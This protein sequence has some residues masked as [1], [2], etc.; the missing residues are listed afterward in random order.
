MLAAIAAYATA[1]A[2]TALYH[3]FTDR[4]WNIK[5]QLYWFR[6]HHQYP[7]RMTFDLQP[8]LGGLPLAGLGWYLGSTYL[9]WL[10]LSIAISQIPHYYAHFPA[11]LPVRW[12]QRCHIF[13]SPA[14]HASHHSGKFDKDFCVLCG[15]NN[16]WINRFAR[17]VPER[18]TRSSA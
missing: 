17:Y 13:L 6:L 16:W 15:W 1:D 4:G 12:L 14:A 2:F 3:L 10:G 11:P 9:M 8:A 5:S 7:L 18:K